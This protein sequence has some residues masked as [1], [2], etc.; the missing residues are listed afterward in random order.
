MKFKYFF[1]VI[2]LYYLNF[3][4]SNSALFVLMNIINFVRNYTGKMKTRGTQYHPK[5]VKCMH[6]IWTVLATCSVDP[7]RNITAPQFYL[8]EIHRSFRNVRESHFVMN[9]STQMVP[10]AILILTAYELYMM[11]HAGV[12]CS[13]AFH[14]I[15][16]RR[17]YIFCRLKDY[18]NSRLGELM[19][20]CFLTVC[21]H[22]M[23]LYYILL[24]S[25]TLKTNSL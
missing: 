20:T 15:V 8:Y 6:F 12:P 21:A 7:N 13:S 18:G 9:C 2:S 25:T 23:S 3:L 10:T 16:F 17:F 22:F 11:I 14:I 4:K 1:S 24:I 19:V 5:T